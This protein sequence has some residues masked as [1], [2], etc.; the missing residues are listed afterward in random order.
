MIIDLHG[1]GGPYPEFHIP[2]SDA[3]SL[4]EIM[5]RCG[6]ALLALS[7]HQAIACDAAAGN[8]DTAGFVD[9]GQ[10]SLLGYC[11]ANPWQA[12]AQAVSQRGE[13]ARFLGVK[14]HPD[15]HK[16]PLSG[17]RYRE[18]FMLADEF[19][20]PVLTH[21]WFGSEFDGVEQVRLVAEAFPGVAII[22]GHSGA[23]RAGFDAFAAAASD[24]PNLLLEL[25]GS[26]MHS[27]V[28][29]D[30]VGE[31]GADRVVFGS[32]VPFIDLRMSLARALG[33]RLSDDEREAVMCSNALQLI[34][35]R[36]EVVDLRLVS[37]QL[38][39]ETSFMEVAP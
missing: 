32:D 15:L 24:H 18:V 30:F 11:V 21:T 29:E 35:R 9:Q 37:E 3:R 26:Q 13:D 23:L 14:I 17:R 31:V 10:G 38:S 7:T 8:E 6:V 36:A 39:N 19:H 5:R 2:M 34:D 4:T 20:M 1:H 28:I 22:V 27:T 33:A 16:Y 12:P 25:S